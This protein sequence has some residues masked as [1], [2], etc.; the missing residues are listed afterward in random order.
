MQI[1]SDYVHPALAYI[2]ALDIFNDWDAPQALQVKTKDADGEIGAFMAP[3]EKKACLQSLE[4]SNKYVSVIA[5]PHFNWQYNATPGVHLSESQMN[6][7]AAD[8]DFIYQIWPM[9][10]IA[11]CS[12]EKDFTDLTPI[13]PEEVKIAKVYS[14]WQRHKKGKVTAEQELEFKRLAWSIPCHIYKC[15]STERRFFD[16]IQ[17]RRHT[18]KMCRIARRSGSQ[19][20][21]EIMETASRH[22]GGKCTAQKIYEAYKRNLGAAEGD[23]ESLTMTLEMIN[24]AL[25]AQKTIK[26]VPALASIVQSA[27]DL[28]LSNSPFYMI[29]NLAALCYK[30]KN[31]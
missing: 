16:A 10:K 1:L 2:K 6:T 21:E 19:T 26:E 17:E 7:A 31:L 23:D 15:D 4:N 29:S 22:G 8:D 14:F 5:L 3:S 27:D 20:A 9:Q 24:M 30:I 25:M 13:S 18:I 11:V 12:D 28:L